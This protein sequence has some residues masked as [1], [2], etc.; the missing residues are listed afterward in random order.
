MIRQVW[1]SV[2]GKLYVIFFSN[3]QDLHEVIVDQC[4][5]SLVR[6][7]RD[8][9]GDVKSVSAEALLPITLHLSRK[10]TSSSHV[11]I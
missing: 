10:E 11:S 6:G 7:L 2:L 3:L 9:D 4:I 5:P 8:T 1:D